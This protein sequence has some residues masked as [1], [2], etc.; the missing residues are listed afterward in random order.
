MI[1]ICPRLSIVAI[2]NDVDAVAAAT[3]TAMHYPELA[4]PTRLSTILTTC[5]LHKVAALVLDA[6]R[7]IIASGL[8]MPVDVPILARIY[9]IASSRVNRGPAF[10]IGPITTG[11]DSS[12]RQTQQ[13]KKTEHRKSGRKRPRG[14][15]DLIKGV[16]Q[17]DASMLVMQGKRFN[18]SRVATVGTALSSVVKIVPASRTRAEMNEEIFR[19]AV[20]S[21]KNVVPSAS[22][23][24]GIV[25]DVLIEDEKQQAVSVSP[26]FAT[27]SLNVSLSW[28][29][30]RRSQFFLVPEY[31]GVPGWHTMAPAWLDD[32][33]LGEPGKVYDSRFEVYVSLRACV[34]GDQCRGKVDVFS[35]GMVD[36]F[37]PCGWVSEE[38]Y[39]R[40][41]RFGEGV[42]DGVPHRQCVLCY[43]Y[44]YSMIHALV[45]F[46]DMKWC[47]RLP[48]NKSFPFSNPWTEC[49][50]PV[51]DCRRRC[52]P[53]SAMARLQPSAWALAGVCPGIVAYL[54]FQLQVQKRSIMGAT[55]LV[56]SQNEMWA[57][58]LD[59][60]DDL[61]EKQQSPAASPQSYGVCTSRKCVFAGVQCVSSSFLEFMLKGKRRPNLSA[62][63]RVLS[64]CVPQRAKERKLK[65][66][67]QSTK[68]GSQTWELMDRLA[69]EVFP[70]HGPWVGVIGL[71]P[72]SRVVRFVVFLVRCWFLEMFQVHPAVAAVARSFLNVAGMQRDRDGVVAAITDDDSVS[73]CGDLIEAVY[74]HFDLSAAVVSTPR[75]SFLA[76]VAKPQQ[77]KT[78][79]SVAVQC[80]VEAV[81]AHAS[82]DQEV[83]DALLDHNFHAA[84][85]I[86][87]EGAKALAVL[88]TGYTHKD[89]MCA[90]S[91]AKAVASHMKTKWPHSYNVMEYA[92]YVWCRPVRHAVVG[93]SAET[94]SLCLDVCGVEGVERQRHILHMCVVCSTVYS[95]VKY[96]AGGGFKPVSACCVDASRV[97]AVLMCRTCVV[98]DLREIDLS[99]CSVLTFEGWV[100]QFCLGCMS[101]FAS[102]ALWCCSVDPVVKCHECVLSANLI[103]E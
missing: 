4:D 69:S 92:A 44:D 57:P 25:A 40:I 88:V 78:T 19:V 11:L 102:R 13:N 96:K 68:P 43:R 95:C 55:R 71:A 35:L 91:N 87:R 76:F 42:L 90:P 6:V 80:A 14:L 81:I 58:L 75:M 45:S 53:G 89:L 99:L 98:T 23:G 82:S 15:M 36:G 61:E 41:A 2:L 73:S 10:D 83:I 7:V 84:T 31:P 46:P 79:L 34:N 3:S 97:P 37:V 17:S 56:Y 29:E 52:Y 60:D 5:S 27:D 51:D 12:V 28:A 50:D 86:S 74:E 59:S 64:K 94:R 16:E 103:V 77:R 38:E 18:G 30:K 100:Y 62:V 101:K 85:G 1:S 72:I 63:M 32:I 54:P 26:E 33:L 93:L 70:E 48:P 66:L 24:F 47:G 49:G 21:V 9:R 39:T 22:G 65:D 20:A 67:L 8:C